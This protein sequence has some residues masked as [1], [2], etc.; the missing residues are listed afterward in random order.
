MG[1]NYSDHER[2]AKLKLTLLN[3]NKHLQAVKIDFFI[4]RDLAFKWALN[5]ILTSDK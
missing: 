1:E 4:E 3:L 2:V 5:Y